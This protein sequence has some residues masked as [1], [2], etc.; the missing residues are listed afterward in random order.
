MKSKYSLYKNL[1]L[2]TLIIPLLIFAGNVAYYM[3]VAIIPPVAVLIASG[4]AIFVCLGARK[5]LDMKYHKAKEEHDYDE[6]GQRKKKSR[7]DYSKEQQE[8]LDLQR[9]A[10]MERILSQ[11]T[12]TRI[13]KRGSDHPAKEMNN[14]IGL[15]PVKRKMKEMVARMQFEQ[16]GEKGKRSGSGEAR[17]MVFFGSPGTGKT[18]V[19]RILTG[20]LYKYHYIRENKI[21]EVDG[22]FLKAG[23]PADTATKVRYLV[24][25]A[26]GG[27]LFVDEANSL[28]DNGNG[29]GAEAVA[30]LIKE[31]EDHRDAFI[32]IIAGYTNEMRKLLGANPGFHSRIK[33]Y[34]EFPD[35]DITE[36]N[37]IFRFMA[38]EKGFA[39]K[40]EAYDVFDERMMRERRLNSF[41]NARTVR[42]VLDE[43]IDRHALN[44]TEK[45]IS[46]EHRYW[47]MPIDVCPAVNKNRI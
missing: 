33:E 25:K 23:T 3:I 4:A 11:S 38:Q 13:T 29:C 2:L 34:L 41:G 14:M 30:T 46:K 1:S 26:Y 18:T 31:M 27:V 35:Y 45:R 21:I 28:L 42:N 19:A 36:L 16:S 32:L 7:Y 24:R 37:E 40:G 39:V 22:N 10:D 15:K 9:M 20:F 12:L 6:F 5:P 44:I 17:H 8:L 47:I 43:T